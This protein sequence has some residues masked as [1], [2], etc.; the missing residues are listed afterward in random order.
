MA[1]Y[2]CL[3]GAT[4]ILLVSIRTAHTEDPDSI[5]FH[6]K[7]V[8][9][10]NQAVAKARVRAEQD[11]DRPAY[12]FQA[13]AG[14]MNDPN[15]PLFY[16]GEY[17]LFYQHNPYGEDW[18]HMHWGHA[19]SKDLVHWEHL[20]I[21]LAPSEDRG[22]E[23]CF[24][25]SAAIHDGV[26]TIIYTSIGPRTPA[27]NGAVQWLAT[28]KDDLLTW[29]KHPAN[30]VMTA[31]LHQGLDIKDWRDPFIWKEGDD[32]F[33]VLG[34]HREGGQGCALLYHSTNLLD[35]KFVNVLY[36]G[37][38]G[39]WE[40]PNFFKLGDK[41]VLIYSP[42]GPVQY[43][44]GTLNAEYRFQP[45]T[46]GSL[47]LSRT[48]YAPNSM[49]DPKGRRILWGWLSI[50]GDGW[51]GMLS[52]PRVLTLRAD[53]RLG[54]EPAPELEALRGA[55]RHFED[56]TVT[57]ASTNLLKEVRGECLEIKADWELGDAH[58]LG[59]RL[60][61]SAD[62]KEETLAYFDAEHKQLV[63]GT[64]KGDFDQ[65]KDE[66]ALRTHIYLDRSVLEIFVNGRAC[67][68]SPI[69]AKAKDSL[70]VDL[71]TQGGG[72]RVKSVDVWQ[73]KGIKEDVPSK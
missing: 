10:A 55:H 53:G 48:C 64:A 71:F 58:A 23:H 20:P 16:K 43:L 62:G 59:L 44:V 56:V 18:G 65:L 51:N 3:I 50:K 69:S 29:D 30:P 7:K 41:W 1:R 34:G 14:W 9:E 19:K 36:E 61:Q 6:R 40:C 8:A 25:G 39:N 31:A 60:R 46:Q 70:G 38:E 2:F 21:A 73:M 49:S 67:V 47:D 27:A 68:T 54:M 72:A 28:S 32:W 63:A 33:V 66:K 52:L 11:P 45:E 5:A 4:L 17:H 15:G 35:W 22:E 26:P 12:H 57:P 24:S 13:P 42:H 37:K